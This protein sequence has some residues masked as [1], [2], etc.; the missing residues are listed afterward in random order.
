[1]NL[2]Y[3]SDQFIF[4]NLKKISHGHLELID[5]KNNKHFFGNEKSS[6]KAK[7]KINDPSF[8]LGL[9]RKGS[10]GLGESYINNEFQTEDLPSLI[11]LSAKNIN[12]TYKFSGLLQLSI[13]QNF[14]NQ[15]I[16]SNNKKRSKENIAAHYDLG[17]EF[18]STWLDK[19]LTYSCGIFN[20]SNQTLEEAQINKYKK[21][22]NLVKPKT[23]DRMLEIGCGWGGLAEHLAKNY[24]I[25]LDSITISKKQFMFTKAKINK[26]GLNHK[27]N[28][29]MLDY[30][31]V[32]KKYNSII[33]IEMIEAV[34]EKYLNQYFKILKDN[35]LSDGKA[36]IQS[37]IIKDELYSRYR[38][39]EDFIQKYI[40]PGGFLPSL[41]FLNQVSLQTGLKIDNYHLYGDHYSNTLQRWRKS[42]LNSWDKISRQGFNTSFKKMW[43]FYFSYCDAG[44]KSKNI[45]LI[46]FSLCNK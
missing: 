1:M 37:I 18:F 38:T 45:D 32:K 9:L 44:F 42:F 23:G 30:R 3:L 36:A 28:V 15:T 5:S 43:D 46:Q 14:L 41:K 8:S 22:S 29:K 13:F 31:D 6:L 35:L 24:D 12:V 4:W 39:K 34:G 26:L 16:Y 2:N 17:N 10:S 25:N 19:T 21:L 40:F 11:E 20:S 33:S 7:V 27:V